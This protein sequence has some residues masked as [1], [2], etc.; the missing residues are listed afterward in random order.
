MAQ[1]IFVL[2]THTKPLSW[3]SSQD[4]ILKIIL[5]N[6]DRLIATV[7]PRPRFCSQAPLLRL[8][9]CPTRHPRERKADFHPIMSCEMAFLGE[10]HQRHIVWRELRLLVCLFKENYSSSMRLSLIQ[11]FLHQLLGFPVNTANVVT[12]AERTKFPSLSSGQKSHFLC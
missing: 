2:N 6:D 4:I 1:H 7:H 9:H 10:G 8:Y 11:Q 3:R 12:G 5:F